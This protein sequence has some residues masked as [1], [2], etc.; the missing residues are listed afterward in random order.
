VGF[1]FFGLVERVFKGIS[2][3]GGI[4][5]LIQITGDTVEGLVR[6]QPQKFADAREWLESLN[7]EARGLVYR[8]LKIDP[9]LYTPAP[10]PVFRL[11]DLPAPGPQ[12]TVEEFMAFNLTSLPSIFGAAGQTFGGI[13]PTLGGLLNL[14]GA[15]TSAFVPQPQFNFPAAAPAVQAIPVAASASQ[16]MKN[17]PAVAGGVVG[18]G[19]FNKFPA[20]ATAIQSW[21]NR[22]I[23]MTRAKL[24]SLVKR[25]G[26]EAAVAAGIL[27]ATAATEL[28]VSGSGRR[29]MNPANGKALRRSIRRI[30]SFHKL[31][32]KADVLRRGRKRCK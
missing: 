22:G 23:P 19:L 2:S 21:R 14:G 30:E 13:N 25:L 32:S 18:R 28:L 9:A 24:W 4:I 17:L 12:P 27:T 31:C 6:K 11:P 16:V 15:I 7:P 10:Q 5:D 3:L 8:G 26:P 29:R 1:D 20:L